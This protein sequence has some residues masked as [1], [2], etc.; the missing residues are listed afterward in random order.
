MHENV[1]IKVIFRISD[2]EMEKEVDCSFN[3]NFQSE[4]VKKELLALTKRNLKKEIKST[5]K[6]RKM[7]IEKFNK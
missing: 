3:K 5:T 6:Q 7:N 2:H 4:N 1:N